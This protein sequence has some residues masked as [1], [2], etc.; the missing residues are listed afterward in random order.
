MT[1]YVLPNVP[2]TYQITALNGATT[3]AASGLPAG[4][5]INTS[6]GLISGT[7]TSLGSAQVVITATL[8]VTA[9]LKSWTSTRWRRSSPG[10]PAQPS[11][12]SGSG[13]CGGRSPGAQC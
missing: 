8:P 5:G 7:T 6:T 10:A 13:G 12:S 2:F 1:V 4:V 9:A 11:S 3:F